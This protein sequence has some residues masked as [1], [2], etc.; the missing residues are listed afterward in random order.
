MAKLYAV[1]EADKTIRQLNVHGTGQLEIRLYGG[2]G[3]ASRDMGTMLLVAR[4]DRNYEITVRDNH[5]KG[6]GSYKVK[7]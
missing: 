7:V 4:D 5:G 6:I 1:V 2:P 3:L